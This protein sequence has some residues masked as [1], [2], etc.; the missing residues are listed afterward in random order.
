MKT[1]LLGC[2]PPPIGGIARWTV[3]M[4]NTKMPG[5]WELVLVDERLIER[6]VFGDNTKVNYLIEIKRWLAIW[7]K[8]IYHLFDKD[9]KIVHSCPIGSANSMLAESVNAT[10][11]KIFNKKVILHFRCTLPNMI[12]TQKQIRILKYLLSKCDLV[13]ALNS[14]TRKYIENISNVNVTVIPNFIDETEIVQNPLFVKKNVNTVLYTGGVIEEKGCLDIIEISKHFPDI[15]FKLVGDANE[16]VKRIANKCTNVLITGSKN[17]Q[18]VKRELLNAD[19]YI[20]LSHFS[21]EGFSNSLAEAMAAGKPCLV[22]DW[23][24][25]ADMIEHEKGGFVVEPGDNNNAIKYLKEMLDFDIRSK[26]G[27]YNFEKAKR[28]YCKSVIINEYIKC[29]NKVLS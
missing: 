3:R 20:F 25:N 16:N 23:A 24:A 11:S 12:K 7:T 5:D 13:I 27:Y 18:E 15:T 29:Y 10:I 14:Q 1:I 6:D 22:T 8:L 21:G 2:T 9:V 19:I 26:Q 17:V 28:M 4:M